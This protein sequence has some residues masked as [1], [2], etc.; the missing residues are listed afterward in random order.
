MSNAVA[1]VVQE[2]VEPYLT[3]HNF[4]LVDIEYVKEGSQWFLRVFVDKDGGIDIDDCSKISG[5]LSRRLDEEDPIPDAYFLE[6]SSPGVERPLKKPKD[7]YQ[8]INKH[9]FITTYV[10]I[11]GLKEIEGTLIA[12]DEQTLTVKMQQKQIELPTDKIAS[13][14][15]AVIF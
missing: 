6:V 9:V 3:E 14:R 15:L 11:Q 4:E 10:P 8:A 1:S 12:Y 2:L 7:F 13:A 5:Y